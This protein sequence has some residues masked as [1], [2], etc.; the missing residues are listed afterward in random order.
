MKFDD[1][2]YDEGEL[3][4]C[5]CLEWGLDAGSLRHFRKLATN[6]YKGTRQGRPVFIK[7]TPES[8]RP[9]REIEGASA[10]LKHLT[11]RGAPGR[12]QEVFSSAMV[13]V[14]RPLSLA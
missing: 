14:L 12:G 13:T 8:I 7:V 10:Y 9:Q 11:D 6:V 4:T 2:D 3:E 5:L 1:F